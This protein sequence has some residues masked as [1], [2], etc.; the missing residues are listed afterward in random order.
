MRR[1]EER[2]RIFRAP[3]NENGLQRGGIMQGEISDATRS[4][5]ETYVRR[6]RKRLRKIG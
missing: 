5:L 3:S 2:S 6:L 4:G 1:T